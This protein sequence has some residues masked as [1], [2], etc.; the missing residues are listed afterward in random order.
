MKTHNA[1]IYHCLCCGNVVHSEPDLEQ[2]VCCGTKMV[3]A[4]AETIHGDEADGA[5]QPAGTPCETV[6]PMPKFAKKPR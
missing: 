1:I 5:E 3:K 4:A 6:P 2:P